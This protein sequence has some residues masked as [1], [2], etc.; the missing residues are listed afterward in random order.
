MKN[1]N[2]KIL[3]IIEDYKKKIEDELCKYC[4]EVTDL[5]NEKLLLKAA[6]PEAKVFYLKM[7]GDYYRYLGEVK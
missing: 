5:I 3:T 2:S 1:N 4:K 6:N 7:Q